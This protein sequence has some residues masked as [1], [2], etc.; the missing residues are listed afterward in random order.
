MVPQASNQQKNC[1]LISKEEASAEVY[2]LR[3]TI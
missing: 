1:K 2:K 3:D